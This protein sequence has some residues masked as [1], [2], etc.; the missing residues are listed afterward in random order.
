[1]TNIIDSSRNLDLIREIL[2]KL[3]VMSFPVKS[4]LRIDVENNPDLK[5]DGFDQQQVWRHLSLLIDGGFISGTSNGEGILYSGITWK[6]HEYL[7]AVR[8]PETW[9]KTKEVALKVGGYGVEFVW[10]IAKTIVKNQAGKLLE[11]PL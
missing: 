1:L 9:K 5:F 8:N 10:E 6:G 11:L 3:E 2:L 7:H 4:K